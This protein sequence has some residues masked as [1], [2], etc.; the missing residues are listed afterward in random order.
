MRIPFL[1]VG[2]A[3]EPNVYLSQSGI[4]F[5]AVL[6]GRQIKETIKIINDERIPFS[7]SFN[8]TL[9]DIGADGVPIL[10]FSPVSGVVAANSEQQIEVVFTP[11]S[12]KMFNFNLTCNIRKKPIPLKINIKGEGYQMHESLQTELADGSL[13]SL[14]CGIDTEN[15]L[16]YGQVQISEKRVKRVTIINSGKFNFDFNWKGAKRSGILQ[17]IPDVGTVVKGERVNC[18][19]AF[20]PSMATAL[21]NMKLAC[22]IVNGGI[23]PLTILGSGAKPLLKFSP[24]IMDFAT[25]FI[26]KSGTPPTTSFL[27]ITNQDVRD[28]SFDLIS[29]ELPWL[30]IQRGLT[31]LSPGDSAKISI[32]FMPREATLYSE[33]LIFEIN[34]LSTIEVP[35]KGEGSELKLEADQR[36]INFS[37]LRIGHVAVRT[38]KLMNK[39]KIPVTFVLGAG[40]LATLSQIGFFFSHSDEVTLRPKGVH[41]LDIKFQP[42]R[43]IPPFS[44]EVSADSHGATKPLFIVQGACQGTDVRLENDTLPFGA[45]VQRSSSSRKLQLQ[46]IGDI[47]AKFSWDPKKFLPDFSISPIDGYVFVC[48][49]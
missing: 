37:A 19:V 47:G 21:K 32:T 34:G 35:V 16:D 14:S 41:S 38:V 24:S 49:I 43:R 46:N 5:K 28:I 48:L 4:N 8:E 13:L 42:R 44:E 39:S 33:I 2:N 23:Y 1:L 3:I 40:P 22:H 26:V 11:S 12:E 7:Y 20:V 25:Q 27:E 30:D 10:K 36:T 45:V 31:V 29:P 15:V 6:V 18:E 17:V 9:V